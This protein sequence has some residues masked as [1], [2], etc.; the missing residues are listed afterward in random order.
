MEEGGEE[1]REREEEAQ[2]QREEA[3]KEETTHSTEEGVVEKCAR[4]D[5]SDTEM[6]TEA[7]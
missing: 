3:R 5:E 4:T 7:V 2:K 6:D 1:V